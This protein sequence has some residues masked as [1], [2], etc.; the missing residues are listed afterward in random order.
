[1]FCFIFKFIIII[2]FKKK[3]NVNH[4]ISH[5]PRSLADDECKYY[6]EPCFRWKYS[7]II[8]MRQHTH[9]LI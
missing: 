5:K 4:S 2:I 3:V 6:Y 1:M 9:Y 8:K 7:L